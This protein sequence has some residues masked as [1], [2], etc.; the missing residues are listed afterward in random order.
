MLYTNAHLV[1]PG[2]EIENGF[3]EVEDGLIKSL[4]PMSEVREGKEVDLEGNALL[5][6]FI[7]LHAHGAGGADVCDA[8][9]EA[10]DTIAQKKILEGVTTWL[11]TTLTLPH[12]QL[13]EVFEVVKEWAPSAPLSVPGIHLEGPFINREQ[14]GAQNPEFV[15]LPDIEELKALHAIFPISIISLA[16]E[17]EGAIELITVARKL[18]IVVSAAHSNASHTEISAAMSAGLTHLTH[19]ANAMTPLHHREIGMVGAGLLEDG[20]KLEV[21]A[22]GIHSSD[23]FLRLLLKVVPLE[24][25]MLITDSMAAAWQG[26]GDCKLGGLDVTIQDGIARLQD[27]TLAGSTLRFMDGFLRIAELSGRALHELVAMTSFNQ[28]KSLGLTDRGVLEVGKRADLYVI[29]VATEST[30]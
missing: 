23:D 5:P 6:G 8:S 3:L 17:L 18:G 10:L 25:L 11:P 27:G 26:D 12:Q 28:A 15:R 20:L 7:D 13:V 1:S 22:D 9:I 24:R 29:E 16:P 14:V 21:I 4:G 19:Y 2:F 30:F